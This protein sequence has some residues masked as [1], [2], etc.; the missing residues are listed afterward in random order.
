ML[1]RF[2]RPSARP[3]FPSLE[4][5]PA[6]PDARERASRASS[7][8]H[9]PSDPGGFGGFPYV[10]G[11]DRISVGC[12]PRYADLSGS[13]GRMPTMPPG[14][15]GATFGRRIPPRWRR[16]SRSSGRLHGHGVGGWVRSA[17]RRLRLASSST[18]LS[19]RGATV[20]TTGR[21]SCAGPAPP[22]QPPQDA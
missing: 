6:V 1:E 22:P 2:R 17:T 4:Q 19:D 18:S 12:A 21:I 16:R 7:C 13:V 14:Q 15:A 11:R 3:V 8:G 5:V 20:H 10:A 9:R